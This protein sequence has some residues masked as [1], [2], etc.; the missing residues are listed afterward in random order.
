MAGQQ[1]GEFLR[2][3]FTVK[4]RNRACDPFVLATTSFSAACRAAGLFVARLLL[5]FD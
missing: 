2:R 1:A 5:P 3:C 4:Q